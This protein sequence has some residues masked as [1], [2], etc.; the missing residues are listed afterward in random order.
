MVNVPYESCFEEPIGT[1]GFCPWV[2][3]NG[4][5]VYGAQ[6]SIDYLNERLCFNLDK[7]LSEDSK[8]VARAF[9]I[10]IEDH[11]YWCV[12]LYQWHYDTS[13]QINNAV[14]ANLLFR[15]FVRPLV[16]TSLRQAAYRH[17]IG[18]HSQGQILEMGLDDL[19]ALSQFLGH[20]YY[21]MGNDPT[22]LDATAFAFLSNIM[23]NLPFSPY[24]KL[25][26]GDCNNLREYVRR[27]KEKFWSDWDYC[28]AATPNGNSEN[29]GRPIRQQY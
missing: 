5:D 26:N 20:K 2:T 18:R 12:A 8:S 9:R 17:G 24:C 1:N 28:L 13:R 23:Y 3:F 4:E 22:E 16:A 10:L 21:F 19:N 29:H 14:Q 6:T 7:S 27:M 25:M 11:L 15:A